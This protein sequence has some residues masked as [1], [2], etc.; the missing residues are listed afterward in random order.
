MNH[1]ERDQRKADRL[2]K[3]LRRF[4]VY[5]RGKAMFSREW[6]VYVFGRWILLSGIAGALM[7]VLIADKLGVPTFPAFL[8]NQLILASVFWYIDKYIFQRHFSSVKQI[9]RFPRVRGEFTPAHQFVKI[10]EE[11]S[12]F[13]EAY[14]KSPDDYNNWLHEFLD[15]SHAVEMTERVL[16]EKGV[17]VNAEFYHIIQQNKARDLYDASA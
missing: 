9:F 14:Q 1:M 10:S 6:F 11:Y 7:Q 8:L 17:D 15:L 13:A 3:P 4:S 2:G 16:R 5:W 12:E